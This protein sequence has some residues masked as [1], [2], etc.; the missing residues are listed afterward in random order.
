MEASKVKIS[1]NKDL[2]MND[3]SDQR[4]AALKEISR[5]LKR[6]LF[7]LERLLWIG[8]FFRYTYLAMA[9]AI[10]IVLIVNMLR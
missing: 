9:S 4:E 3:T 8:E 10:L 7:V 2:N 6:Q 5:L 1:I